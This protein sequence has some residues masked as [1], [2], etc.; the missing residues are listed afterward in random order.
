[1]LTIK[2]FSH[3]GNCFKEYTTNDRFISNERQLIG[4]NKRNV[5]KYIQLQRYNSR[6]IVLKY[7]W[8]H[9]TVADSGTSK[10]LDSHSVNYQSE[11]VSG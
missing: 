7:R 8:E 3:T 11:H 4:R 9:L 2:I 1:M 6:K 5:Y 10:S